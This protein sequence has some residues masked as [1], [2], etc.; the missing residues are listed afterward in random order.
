MA[1]IKNKL[2]ITAGILAIGLAIVGPKIIELDRYIDRQIER[3]K[4]RK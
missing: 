1:T 3:L 2:W 4:A